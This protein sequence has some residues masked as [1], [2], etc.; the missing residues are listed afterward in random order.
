[1]PLFA[2]QASQRAYLVTPH[3]MDTLGEPFLNV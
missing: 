3:R 2:V 1:M